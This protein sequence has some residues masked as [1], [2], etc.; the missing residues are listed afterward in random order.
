MDF[1]KLDMVKKEV[2][3]EMTRLENIDFDK[4]VKGSL[5]YE[6]NKIRNKP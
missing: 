5:L 3:E 6:K 2:E 4:V 1:N